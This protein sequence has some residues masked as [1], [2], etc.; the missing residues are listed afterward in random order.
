MTILRDP[1]GERLFIEG[2]LEG[3][4]VPDLIHAICLPGKT[5][6]L[7]LSHGEISKTVYI[8]KGQLIFAS[9][10]Q[11]DERLGETLLRSGAIGYAQLEEAVALLGGGK[12]LGAILVEL[13]H[14]DPANLVRGL[15]HQVKEI[16]LGL[17]PWGAGAYRFAEGP[18]P[19]AEVI[20]LNI[21][22]SKLI[23]DG[24]RRI[25]SWPRIARAVGSSR[26]TYRLTRDGR[27]LAAELDLGEAERGILSAL[28]EPTT[29]GR[30][31]H[32]VFL[33]NF[34]VY[35]YL[36]AFRILGIARQVETDAAQ[37][38]GWTAP[39]EQGGTLV[40][41]PLAELLLRLSRE[42]ETGVLHLSRGD[43]EKTIH[44]KE[45]IVSF[46][47]SNRAEESL[48]TFLLRRGVIALHDKEE[49]E[50]RMLTNKRVGTL[51]H[52]LGILSH[53]ELARFVR[54]QVLE[55]VLGAFAWES[56][57][58]RFMPGELPTI[59]EITL[60]RSTGELVLQGLRSHPRLVAHP[61]RVRGPRHDPGADRGP[62]GRAR[63]RGDWGRTRRS[64]SRRSRRRGRSGR[65]ARRPR[66]PTSARRRS[67]G[68]CACSACWRGWRRCRSRPSRRRRSFRRSRSRA[69]PGNRTPRVRRPR[70][71]RRSKRRRRTSRRSSPRARWN[72]VAPAAQETDRS[73]A[74]T[75]APGE[76]AASA[77][78]TG[79]ATA[80]AAID[81]A[82]PGSA[83]EPVERAAS[84]PGPSGG[85]AVE[86]PVRGG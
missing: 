29:V 27:L 41:T 23:C 53:E 68:R 20:T 40:E 2:R 56:G 70:R 71:G 18:L 63:R 16:I 19:T 81:R 30:I 5:G 26:T 37:T 32:S 34:D 48:T 46:A 6:L 52:E 11:P 45:G 61:G 66:S 55:I 31:C 47:T 42:E 72:A 76:A 36:W 77:A 82:L 86:I 64:S 50:T 28:E 80:A 21:A 10:N 49:L 22:T 7:T 38:A 15:L 60:D 25:N 79:P 1:G 35:Q 39:D 83:G 3:V 59:E 8:Q 74:A 85:R 54:E 75:P 13:G 51:L 24:L 57:E 14:L 69:R 73:T 9:S 17:F 62:P 84:R 43:E 58:W 65:S 78:P 33:P 12:R 44:L 4:S 67:S